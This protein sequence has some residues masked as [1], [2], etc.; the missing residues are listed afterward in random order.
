M[1]DL[2]IS[3]A[4]GAGG[5]GPSGT[6]AP[7]PAPAA[8]GDGAAQAPVGLAPPNTDATVAE[9]GHQVPSPPGTLPNHDKVKS[10]V[11][12]ANH[13]LAAT[14]TQMVFVFDDHA[15]HMSVKLLDVQTQ[16][17]VQEMQ[18]QA[19]IKAAKA[20]SGSSPNGALVD[21]TA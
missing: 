21:T 14:G 11:G 16:K 3:A 8:I 7:A 4:A 10:A 5:I 12:D 6:V 15:H 1:T 17:V 2:Q 13:A 20:L 9:T 18:P 19:V